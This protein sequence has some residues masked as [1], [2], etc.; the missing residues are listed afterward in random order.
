ML[1]PAELYTNI[2]LYG[3][4]WL[5]SLPCLAS[6]LSLIAKRANFLPFIV[7]IGGSY[8]VFTNDAPLGFMYIGIIM[9]GLHG[10]L[11]VYE[12]YYIPIKMANILISV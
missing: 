11:W 9:A 12:D 10:I 2:T 7:W 3:I 1:P 8:N 6:V 4:C 5:Y